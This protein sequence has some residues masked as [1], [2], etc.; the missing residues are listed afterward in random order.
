[1]KLKK[2]ASLMLAGIMAVSML[3]GCKSGTPDPKPNEGE[4]ENTASGYSAMLGEKAADDLY[5][6]DRDK[7]FT[8]SDDAD[9]QKALNKVSIGV[10]QGLVEAF[11][12]NQSVA[13]ANT[14][15][16]VNNIQTAFMAETKIG[17]GLNGMNNT[18]VQ[19]S[20]NSTRFMNVWVANGSID[21]DTV[22]DFIYDDCK[23]SFTT[24]KKE[25]KVNT[26]SATGATN[27]DYE[28][29]VSVSVKNVPV[30]ANTQVNG[31]INIVAV[32]VTRTAEVA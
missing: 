13:N 5:K 9:D 16:N 19:D 27:V 2:I 8:F 4:E 11:V 17:L 23:T 32:T 24:A 7:I 20:M 15:T 14:N 30:S 26:S 28:Y 18:T 6:A 10:S 1:M 12:K 3:A 29:T 22:M 25:G 21:M 31:S